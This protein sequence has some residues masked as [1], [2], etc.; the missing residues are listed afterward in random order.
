MSLQAWDRIGMLDR[1]VALYLELRP[2]IKQITFIT[3]GD[4]KDLYFR[5]RLHGIEIIANRWSLPA[6][7]YE[8]YISYLLPRFWNG[9]VLVKSNQFQGSNVALIAAKTA[10]ATFIARCGYLY[11][12]IVKRQHGENSP[13]ARTAEIQENNI[14]NQADHVVVTTEAICKLIKCYEL[15]DTKI[16]VIPN[17]VDTECFKPI[18]SKKNERGKKKIIFIGR[19]SDEKNLIELITAIKGL[20]INLIIIG[21]GPLR[22]RLQDIA[23]KS[24]INV[25][26]LGNI[27]NSELP[28]MI[29][30][31][32]LFVLP[33]L[34]E[35]HPKTL[36]EAMSCGVPV[37]GTNVPGIREIIEHRQNGYL[38]ETTSSSIR[39][40]II[41]VLNDNDLKNK[42]AK[43]AREYIKNNYSLNIIIDKELK[44]Y[45]QLL[46]K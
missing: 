32:S 34:Y 21:E 19:L 35:G 40:A 44:L 6:K 1:E 15:A 38:C 29:N 4:N 20:N 37:I 39:E 8:L 25:S 33:S 46:H 30:S 16:S 45:D 36:I 17:Y 14:F 43:K 28:N 22:N 3:Y 26:F 27:P 42:M 5:D 41:E 10:K 31:S 24:D 9:A 23:V 18:K 7:I 12:Y 11:S 13:Q 2:Y